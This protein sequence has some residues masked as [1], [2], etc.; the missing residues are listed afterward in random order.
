MI[1]I[2]ISHKKVPPLMKE[3]FFATSLN[4]IKIRPAIR[5]LNLRKKKSKYIEMLEG[6]LSAPVTWI[7][8]F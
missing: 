8:V 7:R 3:L 2:R 5:T 6:Y 1:L 4:M